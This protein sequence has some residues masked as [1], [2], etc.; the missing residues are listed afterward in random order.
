[1]IVF[2]QIDADHS[3]AV[4]MR[5]LHRML[6]ALPRNKPLPPEGGWPNG[7][8]PKFVGIEDIIKIFAGGAEGE[9]NKEKEI[10][11][12]QFVVHLQELPALKAAIE[13]NVDTATGK[14]KQYK[15]LE[16]SLEEAL[17]AAA[18][19]EAKAEKTDEE[20]A[21]LAELQAKIE[22]YN[23]SVG[24]SGLAVFRQ[25]DAD[26]S[27]KLDRAELLEVLKGIPAAAQGPLMPGQTATAAVT[28]ENIQEI[29]AALDADGDGTI[30]EDEWVAQLELLPLLK[31]SIEAAVDPKTGKM[32]TVEAAPAEEAAAAPAEAAAPTE[33]AAPAEA[34]PAGDAAPAEAAA[35]AAAPAEAP[36]TEAPPS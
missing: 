26:K 17:E 8:A 6:R 10:T 24:S 22:K 20:T 19:L 30:D 3:G 21:Q 16:K 13:Q 36:P 33:A 25:I 11:L 1:M 18:V 23:K 32:R 2:N 5:E 4:S 28:E 9:D 27:G 31:A 29:L 15:S 12:E 7:E 14:L 35:E 34:A